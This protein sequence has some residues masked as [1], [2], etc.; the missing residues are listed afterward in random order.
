MSLFPSLPCTLKPAGYQTA[1]NAIAI[2]NSNMLVNLTGT[3]TTATKALIVVLI[4]AVLALDVAILYY[5]SRN[6]VAEGRELLREH[7]KFKKIKLVYPKHVPKK[8]KKHKQPVRYREHYEVYGD[9]DV[10][11]HDH[12]HD[13]GHKDKKDEDAYTTPFV[14]THGLDGYGLQYK[15]EDYSGSNDILFKPP[16]EIFKDKWQ[17]LPPAPPAPLKPGEKPTP[18]PLKK[19]KSKARSVKN[20]IG[21]FVFGTVAGRLKKRYKTRVRRRRTDGRTDRRTDGTRRRR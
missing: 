3:S 13:H 4:L 12:D 1:S 16:K 19:V 5:I 15:D 8:H 2:L 11:D 21:D 7:F 9:D 6:A 20:Y 10:P 18:A 17:G 14:E